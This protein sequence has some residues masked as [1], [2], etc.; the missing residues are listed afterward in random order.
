MTSY[1]NW[2]C[3]PPI[4][5]K[6]EAISSAAENKNSKEMVEELNE[7]GIETWM[8]NEMEI[9]EAWIDYQYWNN[10]RW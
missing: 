9:V 5:S 3:S 1:D 6:L 10:N 7:R 2:K 8:F 4:D